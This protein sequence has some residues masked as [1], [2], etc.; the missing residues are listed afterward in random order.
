MMCGS[1]L[2]GQSRVW[3]NRG[4]EPVEVSLAVFPSYWQVR[5]LLDQ[6]WCLHTGPGGLGHGNN[7]RGGDLL[8]TMNLVIARA[9]RACR[10]IHPQVRLNPCPL[11]K[12]FSARDRHYQAQNRYDDYVIAQQRATKA[13][14][15]AAG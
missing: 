9:K 1:T 12:F 7:C 2:D 8:N 15:T 13:V 11:E 14:R 3:Y 5:N 10:L 6:W 4:D